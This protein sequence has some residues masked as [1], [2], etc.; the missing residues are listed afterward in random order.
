MNWQ[1]FD[2]LG[3]ALGFAANLMVSGTGDNSWRLQ[4]A[5]AVIPTICL[6]C[7]VWT[8]P[9]SGRWLLKKGRYADAFQSFC[10]I[11]PTPLQAAAELFYA[12]AQLQAEIEFLGRIRHELRR[13]STPSEAT[14]MS[15]G[16]RGHNGHAIE[17][18]DLEN[19]NNRGRDVADPGREAR[20]RGGCLTLPARFKRLWD[21]IRDEKADV[22]LDDY[23]RCAKYSY[24]TGRIAQ[25]F[26]IP[27]IRRA[28][29]AAR[30]MMISQQLCGIVSSDPDLLIE[31]D[32]LTV[33]RTSSS[34][35][36]RP[37]STNIKLDQT[38][39]SVPV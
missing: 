38:P 22:D 29:T 27:R 3:L 2:A 25:L 34:S 8:I 21:I 26:R 39:Y 10:A 15:T 30:V 6:L 5:S 35:T 33:P 23:Q 31:D 16:A 18:E 13:R 36:A 20:D 1:L 12:N 17:L 14:A 32:L 11:R 24:Y 7:L 37:S 9:E 28:T 19:I 4:V